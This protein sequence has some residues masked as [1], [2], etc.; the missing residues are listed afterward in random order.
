MGSVTWGADV[1]GGIPFSG[2]VTLSGCRLVGAGAADDAL[3]L[4]WNEHPADAN[5]VAVWRMNEVWNGTAG[6]VIDASGNGYHGQAINGVNTDAG[7]MDRAYK[8]VQSSNHYADVPTTLTGLNTLSALT[9]EAWVYP[10]KLGAQ[11]GRVVFDNDYSY[12]LEL[13]NAQKGTQTPFWR[14]RTWTSVN[15]QNVV[16]SGASNDFVWQWYHVAFCWDGSQ[17][18]IYVNG[19]LLVSK[20]STGSLT[21]T[22]RGGRRNIGRDGAY[23]NGW[24]QGWMDDLRISSV[25]RYSSAFSPTRYPT[26]GTGTLTG[27]GLATRVPTAVS[28]TATEGASYGEVSKVELLDAALGWTQVGGDNPT[29]PISVSGITLAADASVRVTLTPKADAIRSET[30]TLADVTL[31][32]ADPVT[33]SPYYY[34]QIIANRRGRH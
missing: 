6:E 31:T 15:G 1:P 8:G 30:P 33:S 7:W 34:Q 11:S 27:T 12:T 9:V 17:M 22:P 3:A 2:N 19:Q 5:T 10:E 20:A 21:R 13:R 24:Y 4:G 26:T 25:A 14:A 32:Y 23:L 18:R 29:S 28:W 16:D